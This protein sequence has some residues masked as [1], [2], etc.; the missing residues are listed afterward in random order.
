MRSLVLSSV[1]TLQQG[2]RSRSVAVALCLLAALRWPREAFAEAVPP[3]ESQAVGSA[4]VAAP[5]AQARA[6][7]LAEHADLPPSDLCAALLTQGRGARDHGD[8][9]TALAA[10]TIAATVAEAAGLRAP[11]A[12]SLLE[13]GGTHLRRGELGRVPAFLDRAEPIYQEL[14]DEAALAKLWNLRGILAGR[15]GDLEQAEGFY[16]RSLAVFLRLGDKQHASRAQGNLGLGCQSRGDFAC[17]LAA[18]LRALELDP[19]NTS[20][21]ANIGLVHG[22]QGESALALDDFRRAAAIDRKAGDA[23]G[24][25][26]DY[27]QAGEVQTE[28]GDE[29]GALASFAAARGPFEKAGAQEEFGELEIARAELELRCKRVRAAIGFAESAVKRLGAHGS[30]GLLMDALNSL[31]EARLA[32]GQPDAALAAAE[33]ALEIARRLDSLSALRQ[34][35]IGIGKAREARGE[36]TQAVAAFDSAIDAIERQRERV[37]G[38]ESNRQQFFEQFQEPYHRLLAIAVRKGDLATAFQ[39]GEQARARVLADVLHGGHRIGE[40]LLSP[41]ERELEATAERA[42][43]LLEA[44]RDAQPEGA[45]PGDVAAR[46]EE[47]RRQLGATRT[48]LFNSH[49]ELRLARGESNIVAPEDLAPL[50]A[51]GSV[52][53]AFTVTERA[54][55]VFVLE[56]GA[57]PAVALRVVT[58]PTGAATWRARVTAFRGRLARRDLGAAHDGAALFTELL[59]PLRAELRGRSRV[60]LVPDGALWELPFAALQPKAG[61][62][63]IEDSALTLAPSLSALMAWRERKAPPA[64]AHDRDLLAIGR[65]DFAGGLPRL[66]GAESQARAVAALYGSN[67]GEVL[68]GDDARE[69]EVKRALGHFRVLHF[70]THGVLE[71]ASP[72]YSALLLAPESADATEDG[73]LEA[74]ELLELDLPADLA[75]LAACDTARGRIAAGEGVIGLSWALSVA[76]VRNTVVSLWSVDAASTG[77]LL[78]EFQRRARDGES[79]ADAL[80]AA[81]LSRLRDPRT[82]HPFYWAPFVLIGDGRASPRG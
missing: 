21:L 11:L 65:S 58:M 15:L 47:A 50:L 51:D 16:R 36:V 29:R 43:R 9:N 23:I 52:A 22:Y 46:L 64:S 17:A 42:V 55:F 14:G 8:W 74:R 30:L 53:L 72:L 7:L 78:V 67:R 6:R 4:L 3:A 77:D 33:R 24:E 19:T 80:R 81:A 45:P 54:T 49:P 62:Y 82:R 68:V 75:V 10:F 25:A 79:Y 2:R 63:L 20:A 38:D 13:V 48:A 26:A 18:H 76:G 12:E 69:G 59:G 34:S 60:Y 71:P 39:V 66:A 44:E 56:R 61:R 5:D 40:R 35:W 31:S 41:A 70:A 1:H 27:L 73:R 28:A 57:G 32:A 37:A